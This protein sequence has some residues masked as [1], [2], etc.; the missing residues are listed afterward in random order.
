MPEID[1]APHIK[2]KIKLLFSVAGGINSNDEAIIHPRI[3]DEI[4]CI[5]QDLTFFATNNTD[6]RINPK[7]NDQIN[8]GLSLNR[9]SKS[10]ATLKTLATLPPN[11]ANRK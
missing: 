1:T 5:D 7:N 8:I 6:A 3:N 11:T 2:I 9:Y 10:L 4:F